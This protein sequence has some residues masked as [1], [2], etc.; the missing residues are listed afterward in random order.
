MI[1][2]GLLGLRLFYCVQ[3]CILSLFFKMFTRIPVLRAAARAHSAN[4]SLEAISKFAT[5]AT[6]KF[7]LPERFVGNDKSVW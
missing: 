3:D 6:S 4:N 5:M 2:I 1:I 7:E